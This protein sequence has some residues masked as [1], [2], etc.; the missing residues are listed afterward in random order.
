MSKI[1]IGVAWPYANSELH[2]GHFAGA[3]L[4]PDIFA[5]FHRMRGRDVLM[6]SGSDSHGTPITVSADAEG[7]TPRQIVEK[8]QA[9][10]LQSFMQM[11]LTFDLFTDTMTETHAKVVQDM[12]L[13]HLDKGYIYK[14]TTKQ[15]FDPAVGRFLADRYVEGTCP[16]CGFADARG[17]QCDNCSKTYE[18]TQLKNPRSKVSG[19]T[20]LEV[21][22]TEHFFF[23]L[24]KMSPDL[25][26]WLNDGHKSHWRPSVLN[27][28]RAMV[29]KG[30][31]H[32]RAI[33]RDIEWGVK[34]PVAGFD[35][36]RLYVWYEAVIGYFSASQA[37]AKLEGKPEAWR[38][39]WE[40][41][42]GDVRSYYFL[43]KDN[44]TFHAVLWP[45]MLMAYGGLNLPYDVPAND[46]MNIMGR[47]L[48]KSR[49]NSIKILDVMERYQSDAWRYTLT[50]IAPE[51]GDSDFTWDDFVERVN[52][53]MVANWGNLAN[54]VL[55]FAFKRYDQ[56]IPEPGALDERDQALLKEV[57]AGFDAV[58]ELYEGVKL[59]AALEEARGLCQKVNQY[60]SDK[61]PWTMIKTDAVG[62]ATAMYVALQCV[63]WLLTAWA[64][65][66]PESSQLIFNT[67][68]YD[69]QLFGAIKSETVTDSTGAHQV[70]RY[71]H[72]G[73]VG[74]W[75]ARTLKP[76]QAMREPKAPFR[77]L[78]DGIADLEME[79][80][81]T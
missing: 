30:D 68:G 75:E 19:S 50:A 34:I 11:G 48:S 56:K 35:T 65:I 60:L 47:K 64:P 26:T 8:N 79:R 80:A 27:F 59:R 42:K 28:S 78:E 45:A 40:Q 70:L 55:G 33:T 3:M 22:D 37:W 12:F 41:G 31:L 63:D 51:T 4:P 32:G 73:A 58:G 61:A 20:A 72:S 13:K 21:R 57:R 53:E 9:K 74:R 25:V 62:A 66:L 36:K 44:V 17:D 5:R 54:R 52:N 39:F 10:F 43:G 16:F 6:V 49:G 46:F 2:I 69:G 76:G 67:L 18:A 77:K 38:E 1:L 23:D 15:I 14:E 24:G 7:V 81:K 71:D 29:E